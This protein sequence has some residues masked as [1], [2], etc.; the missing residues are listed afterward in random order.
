V[1]WTA[2]TI[3]SGYAREVNPPT[4]KKSEIK[5]PPIDHSLASNASTALDRVDLPEDAV[6][7]ITAMM[8][9]GSSLIVSD[10]GIGHETGRATDF[11]VLT[12]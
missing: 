2:V 10:S 12:R 5:T 7:R 3:P 8:A 6:A 11:I 9:V 1:R 4:K